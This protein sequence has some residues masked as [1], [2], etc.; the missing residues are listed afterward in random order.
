[1]MI[2]DGL[3]MPVPE[4]QWFEEYHEAK[5]GAVNTTLCVW[6]NSYEALALIARWR[7]ALAQ[8]K[9]IVA[10]AASV[11]DTGQVAA[12]GRTAIVFGFQNTSPVEHNLDLFGTFRDLGV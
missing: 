8:N 7:V 9:D 4:R 3:S 6:E 1:M 5:L 12:S 11:A 2:V 10:H